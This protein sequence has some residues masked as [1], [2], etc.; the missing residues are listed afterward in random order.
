MHAEDIWY[1]TKDMVKYLDEKKL[2]W[3]F[4]SKGNRKLKIRGRWTTHAE[5]NI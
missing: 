4:Q 5:E 1:F 3:V 2:D